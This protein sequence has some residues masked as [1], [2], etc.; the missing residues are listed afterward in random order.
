MRFSIPNSFTVSTFAQP[1]VTGIDS[2]G[3][4]Y[5]RSTWTDFK[6][7]VEG[8]LELVK[9]AGFYGASQIVIAPTDRVLRGNLNEI[10]RDNANRE[11]LE[12]EAK[13]NK[14]VADAQAAGIL[15]GKFIRRGGS[16]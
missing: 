4:Q 1:I 6:V 14:Q 7:G 13:L 12:A 11:S 3:T 16:R 9:K 2:K 5:L 10:R 15:R 8:K